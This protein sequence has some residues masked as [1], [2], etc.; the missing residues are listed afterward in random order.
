MLKY[1]LKNYVKRIICKIYKIYF[2]IFISNFN[3]AMTINKKSFQREKNSIEKKFPDIVRDFSLNLDI[4]EIDS[5]IRKKFEYEY[6][7]K[8]K[9]IASKI[10]SERKKLSRPMFEIEKR[11]IEIDIKALE[12]EFDKVMNQTD[13]KSYVEEIGDLLELSKELEPEK[14]TA[15]F[16]GNNS[17]KQQEKKE[18][19]KSSQTPKYI[20]EYKQ[21][22]I[23]KYL[24]V[25]KK[26]YNITIHYQNSNKFTCS[27]CDFDL[28]KFRNTELGTIVCPVCC[29]EKTILV[30]NTISTDNQSSNDG[31][32]DRENFWKAL[33]RFQG[34]QT[35]IP[36]KK[37]Y[38][39]LEEYFSSFEPP[40]F[41]EKQ[42][43]IMPLNKNG[44]RGNTTKQMMIKALTETNNNA[45]FE[46]INLICHEYWG[47]A[48]PKIHDEEQIMKDYD[49]TQEIFKKLPDKTRKSS[50]NTEYRL[51]Q[52][53]NIRGYKYPLSDFKMVKT[54]D[55]LSSLDELMKKMCD[56][57]GLPFT[58]AL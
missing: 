29:V 58:P 15:M 43:K 51:W 18:N 47:W 48:L 1:S 49:A 37:L 3:L 28:T 11:C 35:S 36:P 38:K 17:K 39:K 34:K 57:A 46:D 27:V 7:H 6:E 14:K 23:E 21:L 32:D 55:I 22:I 12:N 13:F 19:E 53:F 41:T 50:P 4:I 24:S 42:V 26:Y 31:Y 10:E 5:M 30:K 8:R 33:Q 45:Y 16:F 52:H 9:E 54:R 56:G 20:K 25:A 2:D 44:S 40:L